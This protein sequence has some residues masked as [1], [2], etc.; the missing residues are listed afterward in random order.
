MLKTFCCDRDIKTP[1]CPHCGKAMH[2]S[3]SAISG[4]LAHIRVQVQ[5]NTRKVDM[6]NEATP[7]DERSKRRVAR[8]LRL[9]QKLLDKW[10]SWHD[11]TVKLM[12]RPDPEEVTNG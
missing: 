9:K 10:A 11:A 1:F 7:S 2:D 4:M 12:E 8:S 6:L 5:A 3:A